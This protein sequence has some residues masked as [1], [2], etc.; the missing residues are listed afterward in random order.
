MQF[1]YQKNPINSF[2][3][4]LYQLPWTILTINSLSYV[5]LCK[6]WC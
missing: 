1:Q 3:G 5:M 4:Y 2:V 6:K